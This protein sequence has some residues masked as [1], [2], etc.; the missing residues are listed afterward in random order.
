MPAAGTSSEKLLTHHREKHFTS[1]EIVRDVIIGVSDGLTVPFALAAGLSGASAPSSLILTAGLAEVAAG[2]ISMG[3]GG[4]LAAKSESDHYMR[5]YT[6]EQEEIVSVPETEEAEVRQIL[7]EYGLQPHEYGPVVTALRKNPQAWLDFMMKF[8]LGLEK[9]EA[10]R[11]LQSAM[12]IAASYIAG[13]L[14][15]LLP[16]MSSPSPG[17]QC[18]CLSPSLSCR[19]S[20]LATSKAA[21]PETARCQAPFR[22]L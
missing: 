12:T 19:S 4:Y 15:P 10:N 20:S 2:A 16:Y 18:S 11:A 5:E 8:E 6:R 3:L 13:G 17:R 22:Q 7:S 9:P 21:S 14:V 1:G